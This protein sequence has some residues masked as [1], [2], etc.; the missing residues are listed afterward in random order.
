MRG[1]TFRGGTGALRSHAG[2]LPVLCSLDLGVNQSLGIK[3]HSLDYDVGDR[4]PQPIALHP[5][6]DVID[7]WLETRRQPTLWPFPVFE[8]ALPIPCFVIPAIPPVP[9]PQVHLGLND[10]SPVGDLGQVQN[11][12]RLG[13]YS[14]DA[15][16]ARLGS[17]IDLDSDW[18]CFGFARV[19]F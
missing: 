8:P 15:Q 7:P 18:L 5:C 6:Y 3:A 19:L 17:R 13:C 14:D 9:F 16:P 1:P 11:M 2:S 4:H 12:V 10:L